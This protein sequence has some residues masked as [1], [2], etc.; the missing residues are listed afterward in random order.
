MPRTLKKI[1]ELGSGRAKRAK[2]TE[3]LPI[4]R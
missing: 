2:E 1:S 3:S 4:K